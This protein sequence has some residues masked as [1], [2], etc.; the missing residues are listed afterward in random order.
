MTCIGGMR[1]MRHRSLFCRNES[2]APEHSTRKRTIGISRG[3]HP[4][5]PFLKREDE[6]ALRESG[7]AT[8]CCPHSSEWIGFV[9][10]VRAAEIFSGRAFAAE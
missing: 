2:R 10:R 4:K 3:I 9:F 8:G 7:Q 6:N 1:R 5:V